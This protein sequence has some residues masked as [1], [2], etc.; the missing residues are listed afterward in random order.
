[1]PLNIENG[2]LSRQYNA[3]LAG[4][5]TL[6]PAAAV[7]ISI[8]DEEIIAIQDNG[9]C[10]FKKQGKHIDVFGGRAASYDVDIFSGKTLA[11]LAETNFLQDVSPALIKNIPVRIQSGHTGC[12][13]G[14]KEAG[15]DGGVICQQ[16]ITAAL[17]QTCSA[18]VPAVPDP[19]NPPPGYE[20]ACR[21]F[22]G[23][24]RVVDC[25][26]CNGDRPGKPCP[27][28]VNEP[29]ITKVA[30]GLIGPQFLHYVNNLMDMA[31]ATYCPSATRLVKFFP[32]TI[33]M[34]GV[35]T[36]TKNCVVAGAIKE[37]AS[38]PVDTGLQ[39]FKVLEDFT[40]EVK[41]ILTLSK[42]N[43][44]YF[45]QQRLKSDKTNCI[46]KDP[47]NGNC[48]VRQA[49]GARI[50][51]SADQLQMNCP[52]FFFDR[53]W[54]W[55]FFTY[56]TFGTPEKQ[57][58]EWDTRSTISQQDLFGNAEEVTLTELH[59]LSKINAIVTRL[60]YNCQNS[61]CSGA[62]EV[63]AFIAQNGQSLFNKYSGLLSRAHDK[64]IQNAQQFAW[65]LEEKIKQTAAG[66]P[67]PGGCLCAVSVT[68]LQVTTNYQ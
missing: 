45:T 58:L 25:A 5:N 23:S 68:G 1:M 54:G 27:R 2:D 29:D 63:D 35:A 53:C 8:I 55:E 13:K 28:V 60:Q 21:D 10:E 52:N 42:I 57:R 31:N 37:I 43:Y 7:F 49:E 51:N 39:T 4:D 15:I 9:R 26:Q 46:L 67:E 12:Q 62:P 33:G 50:A 56:R 44:R 11:Q 47:E 61:P 59:C 40:D 16:Y 17:N 3:C 32:K 24:K 38:V 20:C 65:G 30:E 18:L 14:L 64:L 22:F 36:V 19:K 41:C 6:P 48:I 34:K 66:I